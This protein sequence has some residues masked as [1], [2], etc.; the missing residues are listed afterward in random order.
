MIKE[1]LKVQLAFADFAVK[2][3]LEGVTHD[4][5]LL[6][7]QTGGNSINW[8]L[9][10]LVNTRAAMLRLLGGDPLTGERH[11]TLYGR[12][13]DGVGA[14]DDCETLEALLEVWNAYQAALLERLEGA[15]DEQLG[16]EVNK[17]FEPE[18]TEPTGVQFAHFLFHEIYHAGQIGVIQGGDV[19]QRLRHG[20]PRGDQRFSLHGDDAKSHERLLRTSP[21]LS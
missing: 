20:H 17:I 19:G 8:V 11:N 10:H 1:A 16:A 15:T 18:A 12:Y 4:Q 6:S 14:G 7:A 2:K 5:S 21:A 9:G 13:T 3:N